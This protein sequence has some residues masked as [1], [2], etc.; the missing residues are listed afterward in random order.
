[1]QNQNCC[2]SLLLKLNLSLIFLT[3]LTKWVLSTKLGY[4][5][6]KMLDN[7]GLKTRCIERTSIGISDKKTEQAQS[8]ALF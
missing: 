8:P 4:N 3:N 7:M 2:F 5:F 1:M 6:Q